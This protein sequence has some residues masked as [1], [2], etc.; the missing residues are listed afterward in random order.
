VYIYICKDD[1]ILLRLKKEGNPIIC[2]N[3][4]ELSGYYA[5]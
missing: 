1:G 2:G 3:R 5:K 4:N